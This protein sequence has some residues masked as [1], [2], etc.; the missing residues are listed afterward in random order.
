M[1]EIYKTPASD[2]SIQSEGTIPKRP[3]SVTALGWLFILAGILYLPFLYKSG[4][5]TVQETAR[6]SKISVNL[7]WILLIWNGYMLLVGGN[8]SRYFAAFFGLFAFVLPAIAVI[9]ICFISNA[10][11]FFAKK[12]CPSCGHNKFRVG[13][14]IVTSIRCRKCSTKVKV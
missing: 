4:L 2:L 13:N 10:K 7:I 14:P 6:G 8:I 11:T 9:Y 3:T 5:L 1:N 12:S